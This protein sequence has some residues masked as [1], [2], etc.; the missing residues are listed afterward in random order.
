MMKFCISLIVLVSVL[1][2]GMSP[3]WSGKTKR[4]ETESDSEEQ[5][6]SSRNTKK[7]IELPP[8]VWAH[9]FSYIFPEDNEKAIQNRANLMLVDR[10]F[11]GICQDWL[12]LKASIRDNELENWD[13]LEK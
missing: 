7:K 11:L 9:I 12:L 6:S 5:S 8:E 4:Q 13:E 3:A 2:L 10:F 1:N